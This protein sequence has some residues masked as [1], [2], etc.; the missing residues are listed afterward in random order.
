MA[1]NFWWLFLAAKNKKNLILAF[2]N[3]FSLANE[4]K[5]LNFCS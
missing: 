5:P 2:F 1:F 4:N 3:G